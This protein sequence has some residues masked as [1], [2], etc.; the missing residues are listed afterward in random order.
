MLRLE[1]ATE[2]GVGAVMELALMRAELQV[3]ASHSI[4]K[5]QLHLNC[6]QMLRLTSLAARIYP[7]IDT[8]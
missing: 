8:A 3:R 7:L 1:G 2:K 6:S 5:L 4:S